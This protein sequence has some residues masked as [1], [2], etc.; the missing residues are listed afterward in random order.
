MRLID[1]SRKFPYKNSREYNNLGEFRNRTGIVCCGYCGTDHDWKLGKALSILATV[2]VLTLVAHITVCAQQGRSIIVAR[3]EAVPK[4]DYLPAEGG[5]RMPERYRKNAVQFRTVDGILLV[6]WVLGEGTR[7]ITLG[8]ANGWMVNSWLPFGERLAEAGYMVILWE[9]RN[10][11]P[12]GSA[13]QSSWQRWD[14][15]VLAAAQVLREHGATKILAMGASDGGN[16]TAVASPH[17]P[18]LVGIA[19]LSSPARSKGDGPKALAQLKPV[20]PAFFAVSTDDPGGKFYSEVKALY[21]GSVSTHKEFHVLTSYEH[22]T[23]LLSDVDA[24]SAKKGSTT[25]QKAER[26]QL[27][28]DL[29]R[30]VNDAFGTGA[31]AETEAASEKA[32][33]GTGPS[34]TTHRNI[35][36]LVIVSG[37]VIV[38]ITAGV[39]VVRKRK[40]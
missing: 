16:A 33:G 6:G 23:D 29:M 3:G 28:D 31:G 35:Y 24:Y 25:G 11:P 32:T 18:D 12:S 4:D 9:F 40:K 15:D 39:A 10:I 26:R 17:I 8:H 14:L 38:L 2:C 21:D 7:G 34:D 13:P 30:F 20:I 1:F 27:A 22:G 5:Y 36:L 37:C 19:L